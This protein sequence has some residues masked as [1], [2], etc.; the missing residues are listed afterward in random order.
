MVV[1]LYIY[2]AWKYWC[3]IEMNAVFSAHDND[4][5]DHGHHEQFTLNSKWD[6][7]TWG[8]VKTYYYQF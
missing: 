2:T 8:W 1:I 4:N 6:C 7:I 3:N 5:D